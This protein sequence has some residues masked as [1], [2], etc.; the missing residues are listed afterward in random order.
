MKHSRKL[1]SGLRWT[2]RIIGFGFLILIVYGAL[3]L[4]GGYKLA[5]HIEACRSSGTIVEGLNPLQRAQSVSACVEVASSFPES[6]LFRDT[7]AMMRSLPNAPCKYVGSW[8]STRPGSVY[9]FTLGDNGKFRTELVSGT[10]PYPDQEIGSGMWG[11]WNGKMAWFYPEMRDFPPDV[12][13]IIEL[14]ADH[15]S[16]IELNG[17]RTQFTRLGAIASSVCGTSGP[18]IDWNRPSGRQAVVARKQQAM[19]EGDTEV[20]RRDF[21][22]QQS[23]LDTTGLLPRRQKAPALSSWAATYSGTPDAGSLTIQP[24]GSYS[25]KVSCHKDGAPASFNEAGTIREDDEWYKLLPDN[26]SKANACSLPARLFPLEMGNRRF[27]FSEVQLAELV[28]QIN[29]GQPVSSTS[30]LQ[31]GTGKAAAD[32]P[33]KAATLISRL[34]K[35]F[36]DGILQRP[37]AATLSG[38]SVVG[39]T[40][41]AALLQAKGEEIEYGSRATLDAGTQN[42][43]FAGMQ[44]HASGT[45]PSL[46]I[47]VE[48]TKLNQAQVRLTWKGSWRPGSS[49]PVSTRPAP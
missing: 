8:T 4:R 49:L 15:F 18:Q 43:V 14:D 9:R 27:L 48:T 31:A 13:R 19:E 6:W 36:A 40:S 35:P 26:A 20:N 41:P 30:I 1:R 44:L 47:V 38:F 21:D 7:A 10:S 33:W 34:P 5:Q 24:D 46:R 29:A 42:G 28:N 11:V 32:E 39:A 25:A 12:N 45:P 2:S 16:L 23:E 37:L 3:H 17:V 22:Q